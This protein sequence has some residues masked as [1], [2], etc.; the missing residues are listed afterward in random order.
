MRMVRLQKREISAL[1]KQATGVPLQLDD[2][3]AKSYGMMKQRIK[4]YEADPNATMTEGERL[5]VA[6]IADALVK[7]KHDLAGTPIDKRP[8]SGAYAKTFT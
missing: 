1:H 2:R 5:E 7:A 3:T 6:A 4:D 8:G